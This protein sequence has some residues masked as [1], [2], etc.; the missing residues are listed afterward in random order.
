MD[1]SAIVVSLIAWTLGLAVSIVCITAMLAMLGGVVLAVY[2]LYKRY[3][4]GEW[5]EF[6]K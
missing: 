4:T 6:L 3:K 2:A 5:P 1:G